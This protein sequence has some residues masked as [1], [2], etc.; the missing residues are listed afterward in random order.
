M[1]A[2]PSFSIEANSLMWFV[3]EP[4]H[5]LNDDPF[6]FS[7]LQQ[8]LFSESAPVGST[9]NSCLVPVCFALSMSPYSYVQEISKDSKA[10]AYKIE[11]PHNGNG[12]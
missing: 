6:L 3:H 5:E 8:W 7:H 9:S 2:S 1:S 10:N 4:K 12:L 11:S